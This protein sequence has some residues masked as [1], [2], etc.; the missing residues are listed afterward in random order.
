MKRL[1]LKEATHPLTEYIREVQDEPV[2]F[3]VDGNPVAALVG[4]EGTDWESFSLSTNP[5]FIAILERSRARY[6]AEGG[7][8]S[9]EIRRRLGLRK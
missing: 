3:T 7:I 5:E 6:K 9:D 2:V 4:I 8:R 1:E